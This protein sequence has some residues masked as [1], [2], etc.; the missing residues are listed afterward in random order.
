[1]SPTAMRVTSAQVAVNER[2]TAHRSCTQSRH[3]PYWRPTVVEHEIFIITPLSNPRGDHTRIVGHFAGLD[4]YNTGD[5]Y[6][7]GK[8]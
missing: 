2:D 1:M 3:S 5:G 6:L 4:G 7:S 8:K